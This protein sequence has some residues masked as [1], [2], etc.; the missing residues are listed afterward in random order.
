MD[1]L[2]LARERLSLDA[3]DDWMNGTDEVDANLEGLPMFEE[4]LP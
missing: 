1:Y 3:W 4:L 2:H